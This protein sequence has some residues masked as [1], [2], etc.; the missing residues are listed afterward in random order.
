[1]RLD[2]GT[3]PLSALELLEICL[4]LVC[5]A[6][7][8]LH[9]AIARNSFS[10]LESVL[11]ATA[12]RRWLAPL[13]IALF[14]IVLRLLLLPVY[15]IPSPLISDEYAYLL[16][17]DTFASG[18]LTNPSP[19]MAEQFTSV[20]VF[21]NP[22]YTA[23][24]QVAQGLLLAAGQAL[25]GIPWAGV[26][27][28]M[29][30]LCLLI[31]WALLGWI[32]RVWAF[33]GTLVIVDIPLGV[34]SYWMNSYWG[35]CI[36][37]IGGALVLGGLVRL[38][39]VRLRHGSR[40]RYSL[41]TAAGLIILFNSRPLEGIALAV[42]AGAGVFYWVFI[43]RELTFATAAARICLP[44]AL[45]FGAAMT[46]MGYYNYRVTGHATQLPYLLYRNRYGVP[47]GFFWQKPVVVNTS[48]PVEIRAEY[49][50]QLQQHE[51]RKSLR[52][53][54]LATGG[55]LRRFWDFYIGVPLTVAL[56]FVP[57]IWRERNM[58]LAL[59]ALI[60]VL[61]IE[62]MTFFAYFPHYSAAVIAIIVLVLIQCLRRMRASGET[63]LFLSRALPIVI[64]LGLMI[65]FCSR[66]VAVPALTRISASEFQH[67]ISR[68]KFVPE[69]ESV[70]GRQLVLVRYNASIP[71]KKKAWIYNGA[72]IADSKI[73]WARE[74]DDPNLNRKLLQCFPGR[75]VWLAKPD[76]DPPEVIRYPA[77]SLRP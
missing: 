28:G 52:A 22:T 68:E 7:A 57:F 50:D 48:M 76:T 16:Q 74:S 18:R 14:P 70:P 15:G 29:A 72:D 17:A 2:W 54:A 69:L 73:I 58:G 67:E 10:R 36:P 13:L 12:R 42:L 20:Y 46:F 40:I 21:T 38:G 19:P 66:M 59:W 37:G 61:G 39:L 75:Q 55:K 4:T 60:L 51:R 27:A 32:P 31:Y 11:L 45:A 44:A 5:I 63:G 1:M 24:Y 33:V 35:G 47:Q 49:E 53:L 8:F 30:V 34:L 41:I 3:A 25:T 6:I 23:E 43:A 64:F 77:D 26:M 62:N 9:P 65:P 56:L 71:G